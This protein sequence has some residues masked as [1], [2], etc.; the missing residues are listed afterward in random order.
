LIKISSQID[1]GV[2][3]ETV[4][5][6]DLEAGCRPVASA[7]TPTAN[8]DKG[9]DVTTAQLPATGIFVTSNLALATTP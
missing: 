8:V 6:E 5:N 7:A 4:T 9:S 1:T 2:A 3:A